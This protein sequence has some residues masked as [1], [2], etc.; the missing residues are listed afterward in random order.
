MSD[1]L[2]ENN[3]CGQTILQIVANGN[4]IIAELLRLKEYIPDI[5][6]LETKE[7]LQKYGEIILDFSYFQI[8]EVQDRKIENDPVSRGHTTAGFYSNNSDLVQLY[9]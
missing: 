1:F 6:R 3:I 4:A 5:Y 9:E 8:S 2:A 7:N